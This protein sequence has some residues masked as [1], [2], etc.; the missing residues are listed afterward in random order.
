[1]KRGSIALIAIALV[2]IAGWLIW[3][4]WINPFEKRNIRKALEEIDK[5]SSFRGQENDDF[6]NQV[7]KAQDA[8]KSC[9]TQAITE[10]DSQ[11]TV[12]VE[13]QLESAIKEQQFYQLPDSNPRKQQMLKVINEASR[14]TEEMIRSHVM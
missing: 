11:L 10:Y 8:V 14:T 1:M 4:S 6:R 7:A 5:V 13:L 3:G 9:K 2:W 12:L